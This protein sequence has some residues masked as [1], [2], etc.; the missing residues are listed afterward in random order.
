MTTIPS[1]IQPMQHHRIAYPPNEVGPLI[2][3]GRSTV[4]ELIATGELRSFTVGRRRLV[5]AAA[6]DEFI[7]QRDAA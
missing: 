7:L 3:L 5:S 4:F 1:S 2:G 6:I